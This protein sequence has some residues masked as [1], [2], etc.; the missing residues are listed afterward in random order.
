MEI[1]IEEINRGKKLLHRHKF[2]TAKIS[3][4]RGYDNDIILADPHVCPNHFTIEFNGEYWFIKDNC[5]INGCFLENSK[6]NADQHKIQSGDIIHFGKS[7]IRVILPHHPIKATLAFSPFE[8]A[9]DLMR[10]P[11]VLFLNLLFFAAVAGMM[12]YLNQPNEVNVTQ[13]I[14]RAVG[15]T[16]MFATWPLLIALISHF[17][18]HETR[19]ITQLAISFA[20]FNLMWLSDV[21]EGI[22]EFN[23]SGNWSIAWLITLLPMALSFCLIWLNC[24]IG[25]QMS[26]RRR[27]VIALSITTLLFGG[28]YILQLSKQPEFS[29]RPNYNATIM[30]PSFKLAP[31]TSVD[32]FISDSSMLFERVEKAAQKEN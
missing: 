3:I 27:I 12:F 13:F 23:L 30:T 4:G 21:F 16:L 2:L 29:S 25:F 20:L 31:S 6:Q 22:V 11:I 32:S 8:S 15:V 14:V 10:S 1:I 5:S 18:K 28:S 24:Y 26:E 9:I 19:I 7:Q 17:N